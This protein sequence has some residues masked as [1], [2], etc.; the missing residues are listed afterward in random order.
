MPSSSTT[1][2]SWLPTA[3]HRTLCRL[4]VPTLVTPDGKLVFHN[5]A[6]LGCGGALL[7]ASAIPFRRAASAP[8]CQVIPQGD[9]TAA[10]LGY[11]SAERCYLFFPRSL[12]KRMFPPDVLA[13]PP[14]SALLAHLIGGYLG[15][16]GTKETSI[17]SSL[18]AFATADGHTVTCREL[19]TITAMALDT[20][21][22]DASL[23]LHGNDDAIVLDLT[24]A[25][26]A[27][28][29]MIERQAG[30]SLPP[31]VLLSAT[32]EEAF[33]MLAGERFPIGAVAQPI[34]KRPPPYVFRPFFRTAALILALTVEFRTAFLP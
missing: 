22:P 18:A 30:Q 27:F 15:H 11:A 34:A 6:L 26:E 14:S 5:P 20:L 13:H 12:R 21:F 31:E 24:A 33:F 29:A 10:A 25:L 8:Y 16:T 17:L 9:G 3:E 23:T 19:S 32:E 4:A 1:R 7:T 28:A 2:P